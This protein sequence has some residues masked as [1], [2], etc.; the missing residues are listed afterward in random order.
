[1]QKVS[2]NFNHLSPGRLL[3]VV[4][5]TSLAVS[6]LA[7]WYSL[8]MPWLGLTLKAT[9]QSII[10]EASQAPAQAIPAGAQLLALVSNSQRIDLLPTDLME[11]PDSFETYPQMNAFSHR[12]NAIYAQLQG[13]VEVVWKTADAVE[14]KTLI[15]PQSRPLNTLPF[16]LWWELGTG[17]IACLISCWIWSLRRQDWGTRMYAITGIMFLATIIPVTLSSNRP[18]ALDSMTWQALLA[19]NHLA[20]TIYGS[21]LIGLF[22]TYPRM[23]VKPRT[24]LWLPLIYGI[25]WLADVMQLM[26]Y[27]DRGN[28][29]TILSQ[30]ML[31]TLFAVIQWRR[32]R[33]NP[34]ERAALRWFLLSVLPACFLAVLPILTFMMFGRIPMLNPEFNV[35]NPFISTGTLL[36]MYLGTALGLSRYRLFDLDEW[37]YRIL[38]RVGGA[39]MVILVDAA[40]VLLLKSDPTLSLGISLILAGLIYFPV[41]QWLWL[42]YVSPN[43]MSIE[44]AMP[45]IIRIAFVDS[46]R[47]R[48]RQWDTLL[49]AMYNPLE[50]SRLEINVPTAALDNDGL[51]LHVPACGGLPARAM[52]YPQQGHRLF[53]TRDVAFVDALCQLMEHAAAGRI[54]YEQGATQERRRIS[55]DM[56]DDVGARLLMLIHR[57]KDEPTAE[58]ARAAMRDLRTALNSLDAKSAPLAEALADWK[59]ETETR[60]DAANVMLEW[61]E[62]AELPEYELSPQEKSTLERVLREMLSNTLKHA[63]PKEILIE[64]RLEADALHIAMS[65]ATASP[66]NWQE[67]RGM[68]NMRARLAEIGGILNILHRDQRDVVTLVLPFAR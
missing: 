62:P 9:Q 44:Q 25:W 10:V 41:R 17:I 43:H 64:T 37:A 32:C 68:R 52:R 31:A 58:V 23:L 60:C 59:Q 30:L 67:G 12:Q 20:I 24:L 18:L 6:T 53:S 57:A 66:D 15:T 54:A 1:L 16:A 55:R 5:L 50:M 11:D 63:S 48:E 61:H 27:L 40:F 26:P 13:P 42:H 51:A 4:L 47:E 14:Q 19:I 46:L 22:L 3:L 38:L 35:Q 2:I 39:A 34:L 28:S 29:L 8:Q 65:N 36:I 21:A 49:R 7:V 45:D 33:S 56:H